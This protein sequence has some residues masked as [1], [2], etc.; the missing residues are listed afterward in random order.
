MQVNQSENR[1]EAPKGVVG[2]SSKC[3]KP[4]VDHKG[5]HYESYTEMCRAW[6]IAV[7]TFKNRYLKVGMPLE[8]ALTKPV[9]KHQFHNKN[10]KDHLGNHFETIKAM[11]KYW[12]VSET[13]FYSRRDFGFTLEEIL[14]GTD[15]HLVE[16]EDHLGNTY[17]TLAE[18][19][20]KYNI[21]YNVY[22]KRRAK[23]WGIKEI[24][25]TPVVRMVITAY[26]VDHKGV[27]YKTEDALCKA[28]NINRPCFRNRLRMG[29]TLEDALTR[30]ILKKNRRRSYLSKED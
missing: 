15:P 26:T 8:E 24:L 9:Q 7:G 11:C 14:E 10:V 6:G 3:K 25:T 22:Y 13:C 30:P 19:L 18:M 21:D 17:S 28:Y 20:N 4:C 16:C 1:K 5:N 23:G 12:N 27:D 29:W 2:K